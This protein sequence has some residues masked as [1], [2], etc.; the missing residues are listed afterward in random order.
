MI[1]E[2]IYGWIQ[3]YGISKRAGVFPTFNQRTA[4]ALWKHIEYLREYDMSS[5]AVRIDE[6]GRRLDFLSENIS[7][8]LAQVQLEESMAKTKREKLPSENPLPTDS[9]KIL[10]K[11]EDI[12]VRQYESIHG[13]MNSKYKKFKQN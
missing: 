8:Q 2:T 13:S 12:V 9:K 10:S 6:F 3:L 4:V 11:V 1:L 7:R 5:E